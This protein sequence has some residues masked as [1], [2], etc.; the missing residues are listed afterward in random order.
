VEAGDFGKCFHPAEGYLCDHVFSHRQNPRL[1]STRLLLTSSASTATT[2]SFH[3]SCHWNS[4]L[5]ACCLFSQNVSV[6]MILRLST[7]NVPSSFSLPAPDDCQSEAACCSRS[8]FLW[9]AFTR[10]KRKVDMIG[11]AIRERLTPEHQ[12]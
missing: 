2:V 9:Q 8:I 5:F 3:E 4:A 1:I 6:V 7:K 11:N 10:L 12:A